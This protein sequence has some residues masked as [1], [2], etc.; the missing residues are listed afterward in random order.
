MLEDLNQMLPASIAL[1]LQQTGA[2]A[3]IHLLSPGESTLAQELIRL[4]R[5]IQ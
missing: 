4:R 3:D 1:G 2:L 5:A